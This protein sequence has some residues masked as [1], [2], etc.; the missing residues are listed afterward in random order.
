M[1]RGSP[2]P[3]PWSSEPIRDRATAVAVEVMSA[4]QEIRRDPGHPS[5]PVSSTSMPLKRRDLGHFEPVLAQV[6]RA[7]TDTVQQAMLPLCPRYG[8]STGV[9]NHGPTPPSRSQEGTNLGRRRADA[10][11]QAIESA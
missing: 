3:C 11:S 1:C 10:I 5:V 9:N 4:F 2:C 7:V 6:F 8:P